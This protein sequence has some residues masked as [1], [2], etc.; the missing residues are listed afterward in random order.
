MADGRTADPFSDALLYLAA[1]HGRAISRD[2]LVAGLPLEEGRLS[3]GL[4]ARAAQRAGLET[5]PVKRAI[6]DI[7]ALVLPAV[8]V[9]RD[10]SSRILLALDSRKGTATVLDPTT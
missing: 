6:P 3:A 9:M 1:H 5:E 7:P 4:F 8:L 10:G 2:A